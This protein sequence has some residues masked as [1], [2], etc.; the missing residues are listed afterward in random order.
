MLYDVCCMPCAV[1]SVLC[2]LCCIDMLYAVCCML[3]AV[4]CICI[5][6]C[7][8]IYELEAVQ[9]AG[10]ATWPEYRVTECRVAMCHVDKGVQELRSRT[11]FRFSCVE[12][13]TERKAQSDTSSIATV[14]APQSQ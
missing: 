12:S 4:C 10:G 13:G 7:I 2:A 5:C 8:C 3:Y 1:C 6:S 11:S 9:M 14:A